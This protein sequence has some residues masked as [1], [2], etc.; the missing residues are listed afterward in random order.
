MEDRIVLYFVDGQRGDHDLTANGVIRDP[1]GPAQEIT[2]T[3]TVEVVGSGVVTPSSSSYISGTV[4]SITSTAAA[5]WQFSGWDGDLTG[6]TSPLTVTMDADKAVTATFLHESDVMSV[7]L[8]ITPTNPAPNKPFTLTATVSR[9]GSIDADSD[10]MCT[11][12]GLVRFYADAA[13]LGSAFLGRACRATLEL[14]DG[15]T[16]G[17]Y[18]FRA[19]Y[20]REDGLPP[21]WSI[22]QTVHIGS[23]HAVEV[24]FVPLVATNSKPSELPSSEIADRPSWLYLPVV[25]D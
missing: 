8:T 10:G 2:H 24:V 23:V 1:G 14:T 4:V 11:M 25:S 20:E 9:S 5:G 22:T 17:S 13:D 15:L 21:I 6:L 18:A 3:L 7:F 19:V 16:S 12:D